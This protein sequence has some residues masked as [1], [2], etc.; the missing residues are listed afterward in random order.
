MRAAIS[1]VIR[2]LIDLMQVTRRRPE[3][4]KKEKKMMLRTLCHLS[5]AGE[6]R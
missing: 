2:A 5:A 6:M 1:I 3:E 4:V